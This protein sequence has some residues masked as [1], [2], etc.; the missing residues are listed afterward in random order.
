MRAKANKYKVAPKEER[1]FNGTVFA[2]KKEMRRYQELLLLEKSGMIWQ[3]EIQPVFEFHLQITSCGTKDQILT[4][5]KYIGDF[6]YKEE[7][8][9]IVEDVKGVETKEFKRKKR[10]MK[11]LYPDVE[12][13]IIK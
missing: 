9:I 8:K 12:L 2:S 1:T 11:K 7:E 13:R 5:V 3:L 4:T 10:W 6:R